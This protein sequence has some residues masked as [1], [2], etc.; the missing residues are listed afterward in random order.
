MDSE[1]FG[2]FEF[3]IYLAA[4]CFGFRASDF[5]FVK[6]YLRSKLTLDEKG[7]VQHDQRS[8]CE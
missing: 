6:S 1:S 5:G 4:V 2:F 8:T 7:M 3:E